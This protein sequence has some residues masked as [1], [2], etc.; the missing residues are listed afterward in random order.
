[1]RG[2]RGGGTAVGCNEVLGLVIGCDDRGLALVRCDEEEPRGRGEIA[3]VDMAA[4]G[5][6]ASGSEARA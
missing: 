4:E 6:S 3:G 2:V 5:S 1:M